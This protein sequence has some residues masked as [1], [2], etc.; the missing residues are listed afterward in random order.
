MK[1]PKLL[2]SLEINPYDDIIEVKR[3]IEEKL[4]LKDGVM[5]LT[6]KGIIL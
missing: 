4:K 5:E 1:D 3:I 6:Y 2:I